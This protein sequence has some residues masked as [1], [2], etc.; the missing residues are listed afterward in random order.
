VQDTNLHVRLVKIR[1]VVLD[2]LDGRRLARALLPAPDHLAEGAAAQHVPNL[3]L[4]GRA[5]VRHQDI[6]DADDEVGVFVVVAIVARGF[7]WLG[8]PS[9]RVEVARVPKPG[10]ALLVR[11]VEV[12]GGSRGD[13]YRWEDEDERHN[14]QSGEPRVDR[15]GGGSRDGVVRFLL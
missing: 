9:A 4:T 5:V 10:I 3:V 7:R 1:R 15:K 11:V 8:E 14:C 12:H 2:H 6:V 13:L